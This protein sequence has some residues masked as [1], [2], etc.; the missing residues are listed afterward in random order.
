MKPHAVFPLALLLLGACRTSPDERAAEHSARP[1]PSAVSANPAAS[2]LQA[3]LRRDPSRVGDEERL[4]EESSR[5]IAAVRSLARIADER[6]F[7]ALSQALAD[8]EPAVIEWAAFGVGQLCRGRELDTVRRLVL[9]AASL[10]IAPPTEGQDRALA[11]IALGLGRCASDEAERSLRSWLKL[12]PSLA[13]AAMLALGRVARQRKHLD[14][15]TVAA[16]FDA[17]AKAPTSPALYPIE[18]LPALGPAA[19]ARLLEV[20]SRALEQPSPG[21]PFAVRALA[22]AGAAAAGP[23]RQLLEAEA[24]SDAE[25]ADAARTL[26]GLGNAGQAEL[27]AA[28]PVRAR[29]LID[30]Q[31]WLS[32]QHGVVLTMLDS[33]EPRSAAPEL[34]AELAQLP[35][36]GDAPPIARRKIMLRCRAA[37]LLAGRAS[38]SPRLLACDPAPPSERREGALAQLRV[39]A[40]GPLTEAR[41]SRFRE[42]ARAQDRVVREAALELLT[43]HDEVEGLPELLA[44]AL[45]APEVGVRATAAKLLSRYPAR[46][47]ASGSKNGGT[48]VVEPSVVQA[49]TKQLAEVGA[50]NHIE[51]SVALL[52]AASALELLGVKPALERAC[53][54]S[55]PTLR[56]AAERGFAQLGQ[57]GHHCKGTPGTE[58][59]SEPKLG[60]LRLE[61]ETDV[62][63]L[64]ITLWGDKSPFASLR[65]AELAR[66]GFF[67]GMLVHRVVPGFVAQFGDPDGDGF[68]GPDLPP[69]RCQTSPDGFEPGSVGVALAGRDTGLSQL[70]VTLRAAPQLAG[71]YSQIGT[72][73]PG[74]DR[75]TAGDRILRVRV[76]EASAK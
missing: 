6:S 10:A 25:R 72:A 44:E 45:A 27:A 24:T 5:R 64:S 56:Q 14:D 32:S 3:E 26:A 54:S 43:A 22:K 42:L 65:F 55:N 61:L 33:L 20:A 60:E 41:G 48:G 70:F 18:G 36:D 8:E 63:P 15:A 39:L 40:R 38:A 67:D 76:V 17:A 49:L 1:A 46:A 53:S 35:L 16:L 66:S 31:A 74:W 69:L 29:A 28:L 30:G 47:Q 51:L 19:R 75:L 13:T 62:G 7:D 37:A 71:D 68:G 21:R 2:L 59:W 9:R 57:P 23:L 4:A 50:S 12:R 73:G 11:G 52:D 34:L 58:T